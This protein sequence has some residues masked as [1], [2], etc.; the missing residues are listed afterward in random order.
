MPAQATVRIPAALAYGASPPPNS[1]IPANAD[2]IFDVEVLEVVP[3]AAL[4]AAQ[5]APGATGAPAGAA[6]PAP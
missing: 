2:L 5:G 3:N 1:P 4:M 6:P